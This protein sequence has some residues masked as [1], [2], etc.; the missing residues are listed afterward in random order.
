M[1]TYLGEYSVNGVYLPLRKSELMTSLDQ[2]VV[3]HDITLSIK[4]ALSYGES[5]SGWR[6]ELAPQKAPEPRSYVGS[7]TGTW[8]HIDLSLADDYILTITDPSSSTTEW[9]VK[10][11]PGPLSFVSL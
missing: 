8:Y 4:N 11:L 5:I 7:N 3:N 1:I 9:T 6:I 10:I 2:T